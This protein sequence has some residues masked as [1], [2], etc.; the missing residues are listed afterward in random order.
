MTIDVLVSRV[1]VNPTES[2][3]YGWGTDEATGE[4]VFFAGDWRPMAALREALGDRDSEMTTSLIA[5]EVEGYQ[6]IGRGPA[7]TFGS[8]EEMFR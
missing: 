2:I 3:G 8:F 6:V 5:V 7:F 4:D 1:Y